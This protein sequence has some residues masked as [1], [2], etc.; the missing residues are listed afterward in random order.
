MIYSTL[1]LPITKLKEKTF[2]GVIY[3]I[4]KTPNFLAVAGQRKLILY[5]SKTLEELYIFDQ[6]DGDYT[7]VMIYKDLLIFTNY[8]IQIH[9]LH[10]YE[11]LHQ[12]PIS[13]NVWRIY[14]KN[15]IFYFPTNTNEL[16][17]Y[18]P[19]SKNIFSSIQI[20][21]CEFLCI[22]IYK[23]RLYMTGEN[24]KF[25]IRDI[26]TLKVD[27]EFNLDYSPWSLANSESGI[28]IGDNKG[29]IHVYDHDFNSLILI[30]FSEAELCSHMSV[31]NNYLICG[32]TW[33]S[34]V[35]VLVYDLMKEQKEIIPNPDKISIWS[36][37]PLEDD[38]EIF[39]GFDDGIMFYHLPLSKIKLCFDGRIERLCNI[40]F[41][42]Q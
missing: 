33:G 25:Q 32:S 13:G 2:D 16:I 1:S 17:I 40:Q 41:Q 31:V 19:Q 34:F 4:Y 20:E 42:S 35:N 3:G 8:Y 39:L 6:N 14:E 5:N 21:K 30:D 11:L 10:T 26:D 37:V 27:K 38:N 28:F 24:E 29:K 7:S 18:N 23:D 22:S 36:V 12:H 15:N 9:N